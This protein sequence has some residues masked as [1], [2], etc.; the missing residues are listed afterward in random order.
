MKNYYQRNLSIYNMSDALWTNFTTVIVSLDNIFIQAFEDDTHA[1]I[2]SPR[3]G[4]YGLNVLIDGYV[5]ASG[6]GCQSN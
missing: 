2:K 3:I 1:Q 6:M 4:L 5:N